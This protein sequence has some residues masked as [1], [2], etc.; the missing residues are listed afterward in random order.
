MTTPQHTASS[1][2]AELSGLISGEKKGN[3]VFAAAKTPDEFSSAVLLL[4]QGRALRLAHLFGSDDRVT[5]HTLGVHAV[6]AVPTSHEWIVLSVAL[7]E[8]KPSYPSITRELMSSYWYE[9]YMHDMF[10]IIPEGHP[11]LRRL[12]LHENFPEGTHPLRKDFAADTKLEIANVPY[13]MHK[14][15]GRGV[16]EIPVGPIHAGIIEPGHFRFNVAGERI[17]TLEGKLFFTHKGVEKLLEGKTPEEALPFIERISGDMAAAHTLAFA[18]AVEQLSGVS[19]SSYAQLVRMFITELERI[20]MHVH[21]L[22][23]IGGM[24][25]GFAL[26]SSQGFRIKERLIAAGEKVF[27]NRFWRGMIIPGGVTRVLTEDEVKMLASEARIVVTEMLS[28][29]ETALASEGFRDRVETTGILKTQTAID[30]GALGIPARASGVSIDV[31]RDHPYAQYQ[32]LPIRIAVRTEGDV[33]ARFSVRIAELRESLRIVEALSLMH[34]ESKD[35]T[36]AVVLS[37]QATGIAL[38]AVESWRGEILNVL[39]LKNG[40]IERCAPRDPSF[41]NWPL[42]GELAPGNIVPDFP[43]CNKSFDLSY[44]G[45]DL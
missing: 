6:I 42:F 28:L 4:V 31:R 32:T 37:K 16:F 20:A 25:T 38:G 30:Y 43:L 19:A 24:G 36:T 1:I 11:D 29:T 39:S 10:G 7:P 26:L 12:V 3:I 23:N 8:D 41:M 34:Q 21:D 27:G 45:T 35:R 44:S 5:A 40:I 22:S 2:L 15:E 17:I 14:V 9:R 33:F 18:Q 13:P